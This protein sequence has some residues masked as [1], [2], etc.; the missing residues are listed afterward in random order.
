MLNVGLRYELDPRWTLLA[1]QEVVLRGDAR[2]HELDRGAGTWREIESEPRPHLSTLIGFDGE[3]PEVDVLGGEGHGEALVG[4]QRAGRGQVRQGQAHHVGWPPSP[5]A[6]GRWIQPW[7]SATGPG[8]PGVSGP[9]V[10]PAATGPAA[11]R[12]QATP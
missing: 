6:C 7:S 3:A 9:P 5:G 2:I 12:A 10:R 11:A 4:L 8:S 1:E